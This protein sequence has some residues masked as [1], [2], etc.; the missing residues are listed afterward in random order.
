M[1]RARRWLSVGSALVLFAALGVPAAHA[2][3]PDPGRFTATAVAPDGDPITVAKSVS[4]RLAESDPDL[5]A[6]TD[7]ES[8]TVMVKLDYDA[9]AA[10]T[11][12]IDGLAATSPSTTG[13]PLDAA[14]PAVAGYLDYADGVNQQAAAAITAAVPE[15]TVSQSFSLVYGG[16]AVTVP[17]DRAKSLLAVPGVAAV[18]QDKLVQPDRIT[19]SAATAAAASAAGTA[20]DTAAF[21]GA[22]KVWP[23]LGGRDKAGSG[24]IVGVL[25]TGIWPEHPMLATRAP[26]P[27]RD[28]GRQ[29]LR[30]RLR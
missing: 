17:A 6:R 22:D 11:G 20:T 27:A 8:T 13:K 7:T 9:A 15:A 5:L 25:D 1:G 19:T 2:A 26:T 28:D 4:G 10:Y 3:A 23:S 18:Q 30:L 21:I 12:G 24:V 14:D 16:L 29:R